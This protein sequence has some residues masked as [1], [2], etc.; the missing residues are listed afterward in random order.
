MYRSRLTPTLLTLLCLLAQPLALAA[1]TSLPRAS[2]ASVT[3]SSS[4]A[5]MRGKEDWMRFR[6]A[7]PYH[8]QTLAFDKESRTLIISEPPPH[9]TT[10]NVKEAL[11][12]YNPTLDPVMFVESAPVGVDGWV[13]DIRL[14]LPPMDEAATRD[15]LDALQQHV[16]HTTYKAYV[17]SLPVAKPAPNSDKLDLNVNVAEVKKWLFGDR[18]PLTSL[19]GGDEQTADQLLTGRKSGVFFSR[20]RSLVVWS[21]NRSKSITDYL[22]EARQF[23]LDSDIII[24]AVNAGEQTL[25]VGRERIVPVDVLPPLRTETIELL[26]SVKDDELA[27]SYERFHLFAGR[28]NAIEDWA[29]IYLSDSLIDT[30]YGSLLNITDQLLK[31][32]SNN[33]RVKYANFDMYPMPP[34]WSKRWCFDQPL[35]VKVLAESEASSVLFNWN[36]KGVGY[37]TEMEGREFFALNR[38][39]SL[40]ITY[41]A[42]NEQLGS[43]EYEEEGYRCFATFGD[44]N[45]ARVVQYAALY[46][47]FNKFPVR[48]SLMET[49][50]PPPP[51][52]GGVLVSEA[53]KFINTILLP[54]LEKL[55]PLSASEQQH[56]F[57]H[58]EIYTEV[59]NQFGN[60][61][62]LSL[63]QLIAD[64]KSQKREA[65]FQAELFER[66][67][68][69]E[70]N[71]AQFQQA[72][73]A[74]PL[75]E[76]R[77]LTIFKAYLD[78]ATQPVCRML[79]R[80]L[81]GV[82]LNSI[83]NRYIDESKRSADVWIRT[84]SVVV[85]QGLGEMAALVGGHNLSAATTR[86]KANPQVAVG[87]IRVRQEGR[88]VVYEFNPAD[89][90]KL[91]RLVRQAAT[92]TEGRQISP[93][94]LDSVQT[95]L[96]A[97]L[98]PPPPPPRTRN[99]ALA[100][101]PEP[102]PR[103]GQPPAGRGLNGGGENGWRPEPF[104]VAVPEEAR[105]AADYGDVAVLINK[106]LKPEG[107]E[108]TITT[109][110]GKVIKAYSTPAA[111]DAIVGLGRTAARE[112]PKVAFHLQGFTEGEAQGFLYNADLRLKNSSLTGFAKRGTDAGAYGAK[113]ADYRL[114]GVNVGEH[115]LQQ[116]TAGPYRGLF[117][118]KINFD[119]PT[120]LATKPPLKVRLQLLY[121]NAVSD[122]TISGVKEAIRT[123]FN[124]PV[125]ADADMNRV[126]VGLANELRTLNPDAKNILT[127]WE[128]DT[129]GMIIVEFRR[130]QRRDEHLREKSESE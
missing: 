119:V 44:A 22:I 30:E 121:R 20:E 126:I 8:V 89:Y 51:S 62:L 13:K 76:K 105:A 68:L 58:G 118:L 42:D 27:Q 77:R 72:Y 57:K 65:R 19:Y 92:M 10:A 115:S 129:S 101:L 60:Q 7:F 52:I 29:P 28:F 86:F 36:T 85:S 37:T 55:E 70:G 41:M 14:Q 49:V 88:R 45:L 59:K 18:E 75:A 54:P 113:A 50:G 90:A 6:E 125:A 102:L 123:F 107:F 26:A 53:L 43:N 71:E 117:E 4:S 63:A 3:R 48:S 69:F 112:N 93:E 66:L 130:P 39:G 32:W 11:Q 78:T 67:L 91:P 64:S 110:D 33:G 17:M 1:Q 35:A 97:N 122:P 46:Q 9:V 5:N 96:E 94:L 82:D 104:P 16:F 95:R 74:L 47:I 2:G 116:I 100:M 15:A 127:V 106:V 79:S 24:G 83:K 84:P 61:G 73:N 38:S 34:T 98:I 81:V 21:L 111:I 124:R 12:R 99:A 87:K 120:Q 128:A 31:G 56:V 80:R 40:P 25:I 23:A 103:P 114:P 108:Y 109:A